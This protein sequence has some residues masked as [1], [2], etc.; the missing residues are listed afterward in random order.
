MRS[1]SRPPPARLSRAR[2]AATGPAQRRHL[3][4][5]RPRHFP[6]SLGA[7]RALQPSLPAGT[8]T[9]DGSGKNLGFGN[10]EGSC[11][12]RSSRAEPSTVSARRR[13]T[14]LPPATLAVGT[15]AAGHSAELRSCRSLPNEL[16][17]ERGEQAEPRSS[18]Y[19][20][21]PC[22]QYRRIV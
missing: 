3:L 10:L 20:P 16:L 18:A 2:A 14:A 4:P 7:P 13:D 19:Q 5:P 21:R 11:R 12:G 1:G 17:L 9:K 15:D 22:W 6:A 8:G